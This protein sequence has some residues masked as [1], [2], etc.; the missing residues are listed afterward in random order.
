[1]LV[2]VTMTMDVTDASVGAP[3]AVAAVGIAVHGENFR[4]TLDDSVGIAEQTEV[5]LE[6]QIEP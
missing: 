2:V 3:V 6:V 4:V 1:M 5:S